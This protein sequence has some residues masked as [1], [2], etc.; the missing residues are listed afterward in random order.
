MRFNSPLVF[1][2]AF[3]L[4]S[5]NIFSTSLPCFDI[6]SS[7]ILF[8]LGVNR[9]GF[10]MPEE[11]LSPTAFLNSSRSAFSV[12]VSSAAF[13][14]LAS[15]SRRRP[16]SSR[17]PPARSSRPRNKTCSR[18]R[19][20]RSWNSYSRTT[21]LYSNSFRSH[22]L[23]RAL[24]R[25]MEVSTDFTATNCLVCDTFPTRTDEEEDLCFFFLRREEPMS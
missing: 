13:L 22:S 19:P 5:R 2:N 23:S 16:Y 9:F 10:A 21:S 11:L 4:I 18:S 6:N 7:Q 14:F 25:M 12:N 20:A 3:A 17:Y 24:L 1:C 15:H 8:C